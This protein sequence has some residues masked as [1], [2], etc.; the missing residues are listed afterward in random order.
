[1]CGQKTLEIFY[2][3]PGGGIVITT[4]NKTSIAYW[5]AI[6]AAENIAGLVPKGTH[7]W[8]KFVEPAK[9]KQLLEKC[10]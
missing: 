10:E 1:M 9:L 8:E 5:L 6:Y 4:L 3:Q 7:D 2:F